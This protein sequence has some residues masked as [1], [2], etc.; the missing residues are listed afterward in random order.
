M[1]AIVS[2]AGMVVLIAILNWQS[3]QSERRI[4]MT[5]S[6][7]LLVTGFVGVLC[8]RGHT[9]TPVAVG[10][11]TA[12]LL[13]WKQPLSGFSL[14]I[15]E[16][17]LRSAILLGILAFVIYPVL[18]SEPVDPWGL[19]AP[20][21]AWMTVIVIAAI[22]FGNYLLLKL[23]GRRGVEATGFLGGLVNSTVAV[24]EL[25]ARVKEVG[26]SLA[27]VAYRGVMLSDAAMTLRNAVLLAVLSPQA[28]VAALVPLG[29]MLV[30]SLALAWV[31][32]ARLPGPPG[33]AA[34]P[35]ESPFSLKSALKFGLAF[36]LL[37]AAGILAQRFLGQIGFYAVSIA[38]GFV[39]SASA[40]VSAG[41]LAANGN[42]TPA[43]AGNGAVLASLT[44]LLVNLPLVSRISGSG[45]S[46]CEWPRRHCSSRSSAWAESG[47]SPSS[48]PTCRSSADAEPPPGQL[49]VRR[50]RRWRSRRRPPES[51]PRTRS[52]CRSA[53]TSRAAR[54]W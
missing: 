42:L 47:S 45:S 19:L 36:L 31:P 40:V 9:F 50:A 54:S 16:A 53:T 39:S 5:T 30:T 2:L 4:E 44:S 27:S 43:I 23:F 26:T 17:E 1:F 11:A 18:P 21:T 52:A 22:G 14:G 7:A 25:S 33:E 12:A 41:T 13:A 15:T 10:I 35:V 8:G 51:P 34:P 6:A 28:L 32:V 37:S 46:P 3:M 20:R 38:G 48:P 29:L 24:A 49:S